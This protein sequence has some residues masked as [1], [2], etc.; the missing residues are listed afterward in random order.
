MTISCDDWLEQLDAWLD[1]EL[2]DVQS[3]VFEAHRATCDD[4]RP[5]A[6]D[7]RKVRSWAVTLPAEIVPETDH[8]PAIRARIAG[9]GPTAEPVP[10]RIPPRVPLTWALAAAVLLAIGSSAVTAALTRPGE[11]VIAVAEPTPPPSSLDPAWE[12]EIRTATA[13]LAAAVDARRDEMDP[14]TLRIVEQ[15]LEIIDRAILETRA[16]LEREPGDTR[17]EGALVA[18]Y[19]HKIRLLQ[20]TLRVPVQK[21]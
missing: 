5:I 16:A 6:E 12:V 19:N 15:N 3:R 13:S 18:A 17:A 7:A 20:Q 2:G 21:G 4:C 10:R 8:W 9:A 11:P 1:G 14:E